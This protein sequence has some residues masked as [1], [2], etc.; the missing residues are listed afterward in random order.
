MPAI[1]ELATDARQADKVLTVQCDADL[2]SQRLGRDVELALFRIGQEAIRNA[3]RHSQCTRIQFKLA[4]RRGRLTMTVA[5]NGAG[6]D[7]QKV[8]GHG[9]GL[10]AM[11]ELARS[12]GAEFLMHSRRQGTA[13][14]IVLSPN[15]VGSNP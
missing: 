13:V 11:Q 5:D 4:H 3:I 15:S 1:R 10:N 9:I 6:F 14:E 7:M 8:I 12:I 2:G